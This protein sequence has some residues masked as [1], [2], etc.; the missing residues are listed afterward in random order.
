MTRRTALSVLAATGTL[1]AWAAK[2]PRPSPEF[3]ITMPDDTTQLLSKHKG[4]IILLE[5]LLTT[6]PHCQRCSQVVEK[7]YKDYGPKGFQPLGVA[8]ND[9]A[10]LLVPD[11]KKNGNLTWPVGFSPR[12]PVYAYLEHP[13][14]QQLYMPTLVFID[15]KFQIRAQYMGTEPFFNAEEK[16]MREMIEMLMKEGGA[17]AV[18]KGKAPAAK[19]A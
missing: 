3:V 5:F 14:V 10:K 4:K 8:I 9:M 17:P 12:D 15:R 1:P 7:V 19:K 11:F 18:S 13:S 16:N 2:V 6:C